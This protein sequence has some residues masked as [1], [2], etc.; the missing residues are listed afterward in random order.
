MELKVKKTAEIEEGKHTGTITKITR[1]L[2]PYDYTD[3][4]IQMDGSDIVLKYG[5]PTNVTLKSKLGRLLSNFTNL[6]EDDIVDP[7]KL[8]LNQ[9]VSF[10]TKNEEKEN[11]TFAKV[12]EDS[13]KPIKEEEGE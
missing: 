13:I 11:G 2:E 6:V 8:M 7:E 4:H 9:K 12:V 10:L 1:R 5:C 3:T